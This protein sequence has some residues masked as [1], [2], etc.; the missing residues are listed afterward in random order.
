MLYPPHHHSVFESSNMS[1][2]YYMF[3]DGVKL[4]LRE[5]PIR[6]HKTADLEDADTDN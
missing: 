6:N 1:L 5:H 3:R 2:E 4:Y